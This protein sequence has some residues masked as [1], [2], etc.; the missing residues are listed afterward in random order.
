MPDFS[1]DRTS[2]DF[3][4]AVR[5]VK[6]R[7]KEEKGHRK[8]REVSEE[9]AEIIAPVIM[10]QDNANT[11][12]TLDGINTVISFRH[13]YNTSSFMPLAD[14]PPHNFPKGILYC[15]SDTILSGTPDKSTNLSGDKCD[16]KTDFERQG[17]KGI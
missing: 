15:I 5:Q 14:K 6:T 7:Y 11:C 10:D 12:N 17:I 9:H 4:P 2:G 8:T 3:S 1:A 16:C 13:R